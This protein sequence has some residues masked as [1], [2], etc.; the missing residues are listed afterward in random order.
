[1]QQ[2]LRLADF[3]LP[4]HLKERYTSLLVNKAYE[5]IDGKPAR[6]HHR[7]PYP[8]VTEQLRFDRETGLLLQRR[9]SP[10]PAAPAS[11]S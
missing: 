10:D 11:T 6:R 9:W 2:G 8:N 5:T 7:H 4:L 1:M 3:T